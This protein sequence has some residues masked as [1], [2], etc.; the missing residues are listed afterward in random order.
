MFQKPFFF[1]LT[2]CQLRAAVYRYNPRAGLSRL[3]LL[4]ELTR[5]ERSF[6]K[7]PQSLCSLLVLE[8]AYSIYSHLSV[9]VLQYLPT[10]SQR[11]C[12]CCFLVTEL[13]YLQRACVVCW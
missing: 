1:P 2:S 10:L 13:Q 5:K 4:C 9:L 3:V 7:H 6:E 11:L 12:L 8:V